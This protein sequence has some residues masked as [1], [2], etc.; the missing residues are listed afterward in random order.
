MSIFVEKSALCV[1]AA[2][3]TLLAGRRFAELPATSRDAEVVR[4]LQIVRPSIIL[5]TAALLDRLPGTLVR[6]ATIIL[7]NDMPSDVAHATQPPLALLPSPGDEGASES[8]ASREHGA[9]CVLTSGTN[10]AS[11]IVIC[12][13][14]ALTCA[15]SYMAEDLAPGTGDR[16]GL[17]WVYYYMVPSLSLGACIFLIPDAILFN[18][19]ALAETVRSRRLTGLYVTPSILSSCLGALPESQLM[20]DFATLKVIWLTVRSAAS[21]RRDLWCR[22]LPQPPAPRSRVLPTLLTLLLIPSHPPHRHLSAG[23]VR[24]LQAALSPRADLAEG[25]PSQHLLDQ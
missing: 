21:N 7:M 8:A 11:K 4:I 17:F 5:T 12:P 23:R 3:G 1:I 13:H 25:A 2:L 14:E 16:V 22:P 6:T 10:S 20:E 9:L 15:T 18:P 24:H 19:S